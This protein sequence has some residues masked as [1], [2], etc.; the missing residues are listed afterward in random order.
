MLKSLKIISPLSDIMDERDP[1][2]I[3]IDILLNDISGY[4]KEF[5]FYIEE[6]RETINKLNDIL[7]DYYKK[8]NYN[9]FLSEEYQVKSE[10]NSLLLVSIYSK[11][12]SMLN[13]LCNVVK[14]ALGI[15]LGYEDL[16]GTGFKRGILYL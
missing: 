2:Y 15:N 9:N 13:V 7:D 10:L 5:N 6:D 16:Y 3:E 14:R 1:M 12:E 8:G 11:C 4:E